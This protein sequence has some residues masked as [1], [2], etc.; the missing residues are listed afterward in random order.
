MKIVTASNGKK[1]IKMSKNEWNQIGK[2]AKWYRR[3]ARFNLDEGGQSAQDNQDSKNQARVNYIKGMMTEIETIFK[4]VQD[5]YSK[6]MAIP[7]NDDVQ[8][9]AFLEQLAQGIIKK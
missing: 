1:T 8:Q 2:K 9:R 6:T 5:I 3:A 7:N 4:G